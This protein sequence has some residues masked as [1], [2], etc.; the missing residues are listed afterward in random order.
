MAVCCCASS[1]SLPWIHWGSTLT[2]PWTA[3]RPGKPTWSSAVT[4]TPSRPCPKTRTTCVRPQSFPF[5]LHLSWKTDFFSHRCLFCSFPEHRYIELFLNSTAS[6]AAEMSEWPLFGVCSCLW[7]LFSEHR[8]VFQV[9]AAAVADT[10]A[11]LAEAE[12]HGAAGFEAH[13]DDV[14]HLFCVSTFFGPS[15]SRSHSPPPPQVQLCFRAESWSDVAHLCLCR[16]SP[17][18]FLLVIILEQFRC[19]EKFPSNIFDFW[20]WHFLNIPGLFLPC[21]WRSGQEKPWKVFFICNSWLSVYQDALYFVWCFAVDRR[22]R[23]VLSQ[24]QDIYLFAKRFAVIQCPGQN[25]NVSVR[26][27]A[28]A[29][30]NPGGSQIGFTALKMFDKCEPVCVFFMN[31]FI[32]QCGFES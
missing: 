28:M 13:T 12:A 26:L 14:I 9:A 8:P 30:F 1:S 27:P 17:L 25:T 15:P 21:V 22:W 10:T 16:F 5:R 7:V 23:S 20:I 31:V 6:G 18:V 4:K 11:T 29:T 24:R 32:V 19:W 2:W 3:S